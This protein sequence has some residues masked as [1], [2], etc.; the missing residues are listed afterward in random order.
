MTVVPLLIASIAC[1]ASEED[2]ESIEVPQMAAEILEPIDGATVTGPNV[3]VRLGAHG[4]DIVPAGTPGPNTGHH[5]LYVDTDLTA[6]DEP[7]PAGPGLVHLG[8]AQTEF[9]IEGMSPG[10]H[11]II[12]RIGDGQHVPL[13]GVLTDTVRITVSGG[14]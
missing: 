11:V 5:H 3:T 13:A 7:I 8:M 14:N 10:D 4:V 6:A 9:V 1:G 2:S 12:A